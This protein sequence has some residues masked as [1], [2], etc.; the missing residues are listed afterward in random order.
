MKSVSAADHRV[1]PDRRRSPRD[2]RAINPISTASRLAPNATSSEIRAA[3]QQALEHVAAERPVGAE[4][5]DRRRRARRRLAEVERVVGVRRVEV[6]DARERPDRLQVG[7]DGV[8]ERVVR[9]VA[10]DA[11]EDR[12]AGDDRREQQREEDTARDR[13]PV[14]LEARPEQAR[15]RTVWRGLGSRD[16]RFGVLDCDQRKATAKGLW[17]RALAALERRA[18]SEAPPGAPRRR[19]PPRGRRRG[20]P[21]AAASAC[22]VAPAAAGQARVHAL[23]EERARRRP[24][25]RR[26]CRRW[27]APAVRADE[28]TPS[29][30]AP[31]S[32]SAPLR[33]TTQP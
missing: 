1:G 11:L 25:A 12:R 6:R 10:E 26:R 20:P 13:Q 7:V 18:V 29:P 19:R 14:A 33:S 4:D 8:R 31:T 3:D 24:S 15:P 30:G 22:A 23:G 21:R 32:V 28:Q 17:N 9:A 2:R 5:E 27:R 16:R